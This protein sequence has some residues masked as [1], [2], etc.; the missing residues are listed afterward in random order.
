MTK[1]DTSSLEVVSLANSL[2]P[3]KDHFNGNNARLRFLVLVSPT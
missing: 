3:L 1:S 2:Q